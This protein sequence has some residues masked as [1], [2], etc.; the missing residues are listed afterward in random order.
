[1]CMLPSIKGP[2]SGVDN[3]VVELTTAILMLL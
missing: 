3:N 2:F 1:M